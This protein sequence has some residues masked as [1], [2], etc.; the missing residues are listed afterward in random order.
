MKKLAAIALTLL[1]AIPVFG[2][3]QPYAGVLRAAHSAMA[4]SIDSLARKEH[5]A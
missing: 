4:P 2:Q 3:H 5:T 1:A